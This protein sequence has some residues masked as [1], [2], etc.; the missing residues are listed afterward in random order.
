MIDD[1]IGNMPTMRQYTG[2]ALGRIDQYELLKELGGGGFGT[3]YLARDTVSGVDVA[4]KGLPP[5]IRNNAEELER[6]R[7]NFVLISRL[8]HP[9][10]AAALV[11]HPAKEVTYSDPSV[12]Q[13]LRVDSGDTLMVMEYA[14]GVTLSRWHKQFPGGKVPLE[15]AIQLVWQI[16]QALDFAHEQHILH[17]DIKPS[18]IM[19]ETKPDGEVVARLLDFGLAAELRSSMGRVSREIHD[20]SGTRPYMA[21]EQ[22][23]GGKQGPATDQYALAVLLY[24]MVTGEVPF[25]SAFD[26][27]DPMVMM[28]AVCNQAVEIPKG[29]PRKMALLR[30]LAKEPSQRFASCMEF[31]EAAAKSDSAKAAKTGA[32]GAVSER[33]D[34]R[35][36][37]GIGKV[38]GGL[39]L[40]AACGVGGWWL[41]G[42]RTGDTRT[43]DTRTLTLPGGV[44]MEMIYC[45]PGE[46]VYGDGN[47]PMR[48]DHGFWLGKYEVTQEQWQSVMGNNP[49]LFKGDRNPVDSVSWNDCQRFIQKV[50][51]LLNCGARLPTEQEWEYACRA[52]TSTKYSWGDAL[53]GIAANC[54]GNCPYGT[55]VKGPQLKRTTA[56]GSY[57]TTGKNGWGFCDMHGNVWEWCADKYDVLDDYRILRGGGWE[58]MAKSC[59]SAE[60]VK[61]E[62]IRGS[63]YGFRLC[64]S[65]IPSK[66]ADAS[67]VSAAKSV[68]AANPGERVTGEAFRTLYCVVDLSAGPGANLYPVMWIEKP[69]PGGFNTNEYKTKKLVLRRID[70][71]KFMMNGKYEV[72]LTKPFYCGIFEVTQKQ[73]ELVMGKNPSECKGDMRPVENISWDAFRGRSST[74]DWPRT[75]DVSSSTFIGK[76]QMRTG[77]DFDL[78]TEAQWEYACRAGTTSRFN[79]GGD[80]ETDL[81]KLGRVAL[82]QKKRGY[83]EPNKEFARHV[84]D[85]KGGYSERHTV[86]GS[87]LPNDWGLYD[88]HGNVWEW[89][90]DKLGPLS[91]GVTD[92]KGSSSGAHRV[93]RGGS[94]C[95]SV[96]SSSSFYRGHN[97]SVVANFSM[98]F[99]LCCSAEPRE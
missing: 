59:R 86:V 49:S 79:N 16:A 9:Y 64:C 63:H 48:M 19:V 32:N 44:K 94:S 90:L 67:S 54:N 35:R 3:V 36:R 55:T 80:S 37:V 33:S 28:N 43:G 47:T 69:P 76:F 50:N 40:L 51:A 22:W 96:D 78:P 46:Y 84:P 53:N 8:H 42:A 41:F 20:T 83:N 60:R 88:M 81:K 91:N 66:A 70:P 7:E 25:A 6:I 38:F 68:T 93:H 26:T 15:P 39:L 52:G 82:N 10:I 92:P 99:R 29:C 18:N 56:V 61:N 77:F 87:Y 89:C 5:L 30:A 98:G 95:G 58:S 97:Y 21:P 71:G 27:G 4:V 24:E 72:T 74:Y 62:S 73:Y 85:G 17:R 13:K 31:I 57:V 45:G 14:P 23:T 34:T 65:M 2:S 12:R 75:A 11:L 1:T